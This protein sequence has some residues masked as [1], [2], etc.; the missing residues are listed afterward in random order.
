MI[1]PKQPGVYWFLNSKGQVIYVGKAKNLNSRLKS[2]QFLTEKSPKTIQLIKERKKTK[3]LTVN[4]EFEALIL[5]ANLIRA[6]QPQYNILLKN[7]QQKIYLS[8][9]HEPYPRIL[10]TRGKGD[11]GPFPS[12]KKLN[13]ILRILRRIFPF[14]DQPNSGKPCFYYHLK[15]CPGVCFNKL[16]PFEY[17][18]TI[19][20]LKILLKGKTKKLIKTLIKEQKQSVQALN[21]EQAGIYHHQILAL[22]NL[23]QYDS[24]FDYQLPQLTEDKINEQLISL[25]FIL[26]TNLKLPENYPL[27]RIEAYDVSNLQGKNPIGSMIVFIQGEK[28]SS[29]YRYFKIKSLNTPNDLK[30]LSEMLQRRIKHLEWG[31]PNLILIDGGRNQVKVA[32][33]I[34]PWNIPI[35]GLAKNPDRL[36]INQKTLTLNSNQPAL[37]LLQQ[38]RNEAHRFSRQQHLRLRT[39]TLFK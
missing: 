22:Q 15:L 31:I 13:F 19:R 38:L 29:D 34:I 21:F 11:Y 16:T 36:V 6:Y 9:T 25:R 1:Y 35:I 17:A 14:C 12:I 3:W 5:E 37:H 10:K 23:N 28:S 30:M 4:S 32:R 20:H 27:T 33:K 18:K 26:K 24:G 7:T 39:K 8:F 2:Y